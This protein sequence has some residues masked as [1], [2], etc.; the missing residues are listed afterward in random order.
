MISG[1]ISGAARLL[2]VSQP[3]ISRLLAYT[4]DRLE[5]RLFER[6]HGGTQPTPEAQRLFTEVDQVLQGVLRVNEL[7]EELREHFADLRVEFE[8][9]TQLDVIAKITSAR[10]DLGVSVLPVDAPAIQSEVVTEGHLMAHAA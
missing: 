3:A 7:T 1:S 5:L 4:Q 9:L 8:I 10:A 6:V 2:S